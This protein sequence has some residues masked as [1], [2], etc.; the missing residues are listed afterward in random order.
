MTD[1][2]STDMSTENVAISYDE[3]RSIEQYDKLTVSHSHR[4]HDIQLCSR[5][6]LAD[7]RYCD[8]QDVL[9]RFLVQKCV[10]KQTSIIVCNP[11]LKDGVTDI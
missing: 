5:K 1:V 4:W 7:L 8:S 6:L 9:S 2:G 3:E 11:A 10:P